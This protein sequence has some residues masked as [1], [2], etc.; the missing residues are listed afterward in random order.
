MARHLFAPERYY[1]TIG[2]HPPELRIA[3]GDTVVTTTVDSMGQDATGTQIAPRFNPMTGPFFIEG[4][5]PGDTLIVH[6]D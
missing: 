3:P 2:S 5:E 1:T 6:L 4:A